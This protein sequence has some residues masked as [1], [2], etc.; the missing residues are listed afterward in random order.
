MKE[1]VQ[2]LY[3][4]IKKPLRGS[5]FFW[6]FI[7]ILSFKPGG[8]NGI[9]KLPVTRKELKIKNA[10]QSIQIDGDIS[11]I[12]TNDPAGTII[13]EGKEKELQKI[14]PVFENKILIIDANRK[15]LFGKLTIYLSALNLKTIQLNGDGNIFSNDFIKS[16]H[17]RISL[18]GNIVV[19]VKTMGQLDFNTT[20]N[21]ELV[22]KRPLLKTKTKNQP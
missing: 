11:V 12:L 20:D 14:T 16:D 18:N 10:F 2:R 8:D 13:I 9:L 21:I 4:I 15:Q 1:N 3:H 7:L 6:P 19:K 17:L 22:R 5:L